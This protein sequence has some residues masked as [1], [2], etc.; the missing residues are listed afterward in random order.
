MC[1]NNNLQIGY[2]IDIDSIHDIMFDVYILSIVVTL[3]D[4][5]NQ[6]YPR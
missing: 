2:I 4:E 6:N 5:K 3:S 1:N